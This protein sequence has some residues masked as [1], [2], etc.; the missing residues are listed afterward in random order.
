MLC[1]KSLTFRRKLTCCF[2]FVC[3]MTHSAVQADSRAID[4]SQVNFRDLESRRVVSE[5]DME[6]L[7]RAQP[8]NVKVC[9]LCA[10]VLCSS[11]DAHAHHICRCAQQYMECS[12][13]NGYGL[14]HFYT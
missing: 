2:W 6:Q 10:P 1:A 3:R 4:T 11:L 8:P 7:I 14:R 13:R 9:S 5:A 12:L